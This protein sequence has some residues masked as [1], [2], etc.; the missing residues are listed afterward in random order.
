MRWSEA[1]EVVAGLAI[2][3]RIAVHCLRSELFMPPYDELIKYLKDGKTTKEDLIIN[4]GLDA[5]QTALHAQENVNG[6]GTSD[7]LKILEETHSLYS[8]GQQLEKLGK[9]MQKGD[10]PDPGKLAHISKQFQSGKT[11]RM[12]LSSI[13]STE[14]PFIKCGWPPIDDHL[15]GFPVSGLVTV[16]GSPG[17]G[18]STW[19]TKIS[20][21]FAKKHKNK[22]VG[23]YSLEMLSGE[24]ANRFREIEKLDKDVE[25]RIEINDRPMNVHEV[26]ADAATIDNLGIMIIDFADYMVRGEITESSMGEIYRTLAIAAKMFECPII[27]LNQLNRSYV[28]GIPR[29]TAIRYTSLAEILSW[30][31]LMLYNPSKDFYEAKDDEILPIRDGASY[32]LAWKVRG[33]FRLHPDDCPGAIL[34]GFRGDKG[35]YSDKSKWF[36]L[37]KE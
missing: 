2:E 20:S 23:V 1:T 28:G 29:P 6:L 4:I 24:I 37:K 26:V 17:T 14:V 9:S 13:V 27:L 7:W 18:K 32:I 10:T 34:T 36:S 31:I 8:A 3:N 5:V 33:G 25:D 16:G 21:S 22:I 35:W 15:G 12:P 11:E 30:M 19:V